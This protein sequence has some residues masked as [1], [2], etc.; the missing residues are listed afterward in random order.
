MSDGQSDAQESHGD[1]VA[2]STPVISSL[3]QAAA[4]PSVGTSTPV[5]EELSEQ[6]CVRDVAS[7]RSAQSLTY[8]SLQYSTPQA[9][10]SS[11]HL[12]D[13][14]DSCRVDPLETHS[15][16]ADDIRQLADRHDRPCGHDGACHRLGAGLAALAVAKQPISNDASGFEAQ[17]IDSP[18]K[19]VIKPELS[20][21]LNSF[22]VSFY[23]TQDNLLNFVEFFLLS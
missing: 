4:S 17:S 7:P 16:L 14:S 8:K 11:D 21:E 19:K 5:E 12:R 23:F 9:S 1:S 2:P 3:G 15:V 20:F 22:S 10:K 6:R 13:F 18:A